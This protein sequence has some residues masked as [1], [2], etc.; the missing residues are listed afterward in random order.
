MYIPYYCFFQA[1]DGIR[2]RTVT[3]VQTCALPISPP[4]ALRRRRYD[5]SER[6]RRARRAR[7]GRPR[8]SR[9]AGGPG[10]S[11]RTGGRR[12]RLDE[13]VPRAAAPLVGGVG[14]TPFVEGL[15]WSCRGKDAGSVR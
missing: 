3:G 5:R 7:G 15:R 14:G 1:E 9:L 8:R 10:G 12:G 11:R 4:G 2:D 13:R 6:L